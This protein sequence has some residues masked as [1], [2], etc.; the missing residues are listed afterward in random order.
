MFVISFF[1]G[2]LNVE[3]SKVLAAL[4]E[5]DCGDATVNP[6]KFY[7]VFKEAVPHFSGYRWVELNVFY[8]CTL[9]VQLLLA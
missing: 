9:Y 1:V 3:F 5:C 8:C 7:Y 4:W 6:A 2:D